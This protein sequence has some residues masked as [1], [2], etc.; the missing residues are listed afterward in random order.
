LENLRFYAATVL[1]GTLPYALLHPFAM[2]GVFLAHREPRDRARWGVL[3]LFTAAHLFFYVMVAKHYPWYLIPVYP[4]LCAFLGVW[5][6]DLWRR[7]SG[8]FAIA[9]GGVAG[10]GALWL[11]VAMER[12]NPFARS[13]YVIPMRVTWRDWPGMEP[14]AGALLSALLLAAALLAL[15]RLLDAR[16]PRIFASVLITA[17]IGFA[18]LRVA[19]PL[20]YLDHQS[21][22][23]R[24]QAQL[25]AELAAGSQLEYPVDVPERS[26]RLI[27][28]YFADDFDIDYVGNDATVNS[29]G[30]PTVYYQLFEKGSRE[31]FHPRMTR[32]ALF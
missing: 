4:L 21:K 12:Y 15:R 17:L 13:A 1:F 27:R 19:L 18:A 7:D 14:W 24:F 16:F 23:A 22:L 5:L 29:P 20:R 9:A 3:A 6:R 30:G 32:D 28:F 11:V 10:A 8:L 25:I 31:R 26:L 2:V